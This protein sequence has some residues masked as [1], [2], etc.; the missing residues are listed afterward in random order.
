MTKPL[1]DD[2]VQEPKET[3]REKI[4]RN[5]KA[6]STRWKVICDIG[7]LSCRFPT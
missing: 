1:D 4:D 7:R 2:E 3:S 5:P 6:Y